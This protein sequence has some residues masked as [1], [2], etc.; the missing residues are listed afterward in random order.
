M[1]KVI[2]EWDFRI[3]ITWWTHIRVFGKNQKISLPCPYAATLGKKSEQSYERILRF[4]VYAQTDTGKFQ[5]PNR[6]MRGPIRSWRVMRLKIS[7]DG[8]QVVKTHLSKIFLKI[9]LFSKRH[10]YDEGH[11]SWWGEKTIFENYSRGTSAC[12]ENF[13]FYIFNVLYCI[14]PFRYMV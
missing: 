6:L 14:L 5:C 8:K 13:W 10:P 11:N 7:Q 12:Y 2:E 1:H 4:K 3:K 9:L